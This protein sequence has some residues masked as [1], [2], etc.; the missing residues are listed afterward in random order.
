MWKLAYRENND[1][2]ENFYKASKKYKIQG[3]SK[4]NQTNRR[5]YCSII[6]MIKGILCEQ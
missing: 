1:D 5:E 4:K 6:E 3:I 2:E